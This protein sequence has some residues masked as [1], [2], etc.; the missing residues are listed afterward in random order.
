MAGQEH[1]LDMVLTLAHDPLITLTSH[2]HLSI[3]PSMLHTFG[4][5]LNDKSIEAMVEKKRKLRTGS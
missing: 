5:T 3:L 1:S 2:S 4:M